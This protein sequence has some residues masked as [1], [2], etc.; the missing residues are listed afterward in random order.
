[1]LGRNAPGP[2]SCGD[3]SEGGG[4]QREIEERGMGGDEKG[5]LCA[6]LGTRSVQT[7]GTETDLV[8]HGGLNTVD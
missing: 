3:P 6:G 2:R 5:A 1:M 7:G 4:R 8:K